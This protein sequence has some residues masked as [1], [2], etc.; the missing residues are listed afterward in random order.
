MIRPLR[1]RHRAIFVVLALALP[2]GLAGALLSRPADSAVDALPEA[3]RAPAVA[4][5]GEV[6]W[7]L[8]GGWDGVPL[9]AE[10]RVDGGGAALVVTPLED[11]R[12]PDLL[13]YWSPEGAGQRALADGEALLLGRVAGSRPV[14]LPVARE[15]LDRGGYLL[16]FSLAQ[17]QVIASAPIELKGQTVPAGGAR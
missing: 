17:G 15:A 5:A 3:L 16:L 2:V 4:A 11:P 10:L 12:L 9:D 13:V 8:A 7:S 14:S 6:A 1:A